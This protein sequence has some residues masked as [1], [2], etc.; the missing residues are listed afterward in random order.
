[1]N[2]RA[3]TSLFFCVYF[4]LTA[5]SPLTYA[6]HEKRTDDGSLEAPH[7]GADLQSPHDFLWELIAGTL[8]SR[9]SA[10][11]GKS[12]ST[13]LIQ[14]KR[15]LIPEDDTAGLNL[16]GPIILKAGHAAL[17]RDVLVSAVDPGAHLNPQTGFHPIYAGHAPPVS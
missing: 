11:S 6:V 7:S 2:N 15:A 8:A 9:N 12:V 16:P 13:V 14:Q 3:L 4:L 17:A 5:T 1:M 10:G